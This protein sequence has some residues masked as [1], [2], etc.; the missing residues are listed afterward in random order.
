MTRK[1]PEK[2]RKQC[3][4]KKN[5]VLKYFCAFTKTPIQLFC[6]AE[7]RPQ[8][9]NTLRVSIL[10]FGERAQDPHFKKQ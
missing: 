5:S 4:H 9:P 7:L 1:A 3:T 10:F 2:H 6:I 8:H